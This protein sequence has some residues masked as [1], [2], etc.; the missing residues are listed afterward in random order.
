MLRGG[1]ESRRRLCYGGGVGLRES[2]DLQ[3]VVSHMLTVG[4]YLVRVTYVKG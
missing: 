3:C 2:R 4:R 1:L